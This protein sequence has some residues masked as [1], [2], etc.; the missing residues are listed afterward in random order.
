MKRRKEREF[1]LKI[2]YAVE[3]NPSP[4]TEQIEQMDSHYKKNASDFS[5][6]IIEIC[7]SN[8]DELDSKIKSQLKNWDF[9]RVAIIDKILLRM[10]LAEFLYIDSV[11][12]GVTINE[13]IEVSKIYS[14]E[15]SSRFINGILDAVLKKLSAENLIKKTGRGL[16]SK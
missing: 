11:P 7:S 14:T 13:M 16:I 1:A 9:N 3:L 5:K 4:F 2:L 6:Q 15:R 12:P 10:A 8:K